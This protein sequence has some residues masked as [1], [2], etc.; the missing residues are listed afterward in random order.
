M[1]F[2]RINRDDAERVYAAYQNVAGAT[3]T[4]GYPAVWSSATPNGVKV[5]KPSTA[6]LSAF[7]GLAAKDILDSA[8]G[9]FQCY[10]FKQSGF[11]TN[12]TSVAIAA[13]D[14]LVPVNA[15]WYLTR[16]GAGDGK[17]GFLIA[18]AAVATATT[19]AGAL[20]NVFIRA[21]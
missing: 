4:A 15:Q 11:V 7:V 8:Y 16:S 17:S 20:S 9:L 2:Q 18:G 21:M 13:G 19:P 14:I 3:I 1:L 12:D 6:L 10:G 5:T